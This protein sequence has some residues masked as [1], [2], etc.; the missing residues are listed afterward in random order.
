MEKQLDRI[1]EGDVAW[2]DMMKDFHGRLGEWIEE[3]KTAHMDLDEIRALFA[4]TDEITEF[5]PP[6][7]RGKKE[8]CDKTFLAEMR[9]AIDAGEAITDR[10]LENIRKVAAKYAE[11]IPSLDEAK[12]EELDLTELIAKEKE[13]NR[14]PRDETLGKFELMANIE[15]APARKVGKKTYDDAEFLGSL[16]E[17]VEGGRR[18]TDN[19]VK[20][21]DRL[22]VK[23]AA[24]IPDFET[25]AKELGINAEQ[26]EDNESGPLLELLAHVSTFNE[27][28]QRGKRTWDDAEFAES[29]KQQFA[30]RKSL[31]PRQR[32]ALKTMLGRYHEQ[33]PGYMEKREAL[34]LR[35]PNA[36][37]KTGG[38]RKAKA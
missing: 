33:I 9:E 28:T 13:A 37:R 14:P 32:N 36:K 29:L 24:Q 3:A 4:L 22:V 8:Y 10:Q 6:V 16:K 30:A 38:R 34:G 19:Q 11:Q 1:E 26:E 21:L 15:F 25:K 5:N 35:D 17:Q 27:P 20:Y 7:Q 12:A 2:T 31:T 18:L 23:Y